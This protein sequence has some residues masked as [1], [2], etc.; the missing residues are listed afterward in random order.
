VQRTKMQGL[1]LAKINSHSCQKPLF[2]VIKQRVYN[3]VNCIL[4]RVRTTKIQI[5]N[6]TL[7]TV[8]TSSL[9]L[10]IRLHHPLSR[11]F[12]L[13]GS[14]CCTE[15]RKTKRGEDKPAKTAEGT[16]IELESV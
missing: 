7:L 16:G 11:E 10:I 9:Y 4:S 2:S 6:P 3:S 8:L 1:Q 15:K 12:A 14:S 13:E 5:K